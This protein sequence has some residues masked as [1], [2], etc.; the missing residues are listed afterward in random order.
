[1]KLARYAQGGQV[2]W[3]VIDDGVIRQIGSQFAEWAPKLTVKADKGALVPRP[4]RGGGAEAIGSL[5]GCDTGQCDTECTPTH[6]LWQQ[7]V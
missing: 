7:P 1:M 2:S 3:G 4:L 6:A 5:G